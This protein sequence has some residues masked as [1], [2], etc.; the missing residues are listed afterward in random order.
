MSSKPPTPMGYWWSTLA[1]QWL[2]QKT[3]RWNSFFLC[4]PPNTEKKE[5]KFCNMTDQTTVCKNG[6]LVRKCAHFKQ[7]KRSKNLCKS[8][9]YLWTPRAMNHP[10]KTAINRSA[11][12]TMHPARNRIIIIQKAE[13][14]K[15]T[16][17]RMRIRYHDST[18][19]AYNRWNVSLIRNALSNAVTE[20]CKDFKV[21]PLEV[22]WS[23]AS[24]IESLER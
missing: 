12:H 14:M 19:S 1:I 17:N 10:E 13:R 21:N 22:G 23:F 8:T 15:A 20:S 16:R 3:G 7:G 2:A 4:F 6:L 18:T 24:T 9:V 5:E 11:V